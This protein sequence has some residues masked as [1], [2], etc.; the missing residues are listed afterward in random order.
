MRL[1]QGTLPVPRELLQILAVSA[2]RSLLIH[3]M[4]YSRHS[5]ARILV[6]GAE[7]SAFAVRVRQEM[8]GTSMAARVVH[9][10]YAEVPHMTSSVAHAAF[11]HLYGHI[12]N[13]E[14][15]VHS[16]GENRVLL[17]GAG[18]KGQSAVAIC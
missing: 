3:G 5:L 14:R 10:V 11:L 17:I 16:A 6:M 8:Q 13:A 2:N 7:R 1:V 4:C 18:C 9:D 15:S 12:A